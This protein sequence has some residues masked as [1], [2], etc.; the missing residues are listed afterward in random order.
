[1]GCLNLMFSLPLL[2]LLFLEGIR[3]HPRNVVCEKV[4]A[5]GR[6]GDYELRQDLQDGF[7]AEGFTIGCEGKLDFLG[8]DWKGHKQRVLRRENVQC[9]EVWHG[10]ITFIGTAHV[11]A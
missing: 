5:L 1:M 6:F 11:H 2:R 8:Q 10:A 7:H 3:T 4:I 9:G